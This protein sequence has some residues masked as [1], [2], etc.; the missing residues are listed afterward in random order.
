MTVKINGISHIFQ[1]KAGEIPALDDVSAT[2]SEGEFV[3]VVGPSGCGKSTLLRIVAGLITPTQG[4]IEID[5]KSVEEP[6]GD[7]GFVFQKPVLFPW[8][9][10]TANVMFPYEMRAQRDRDLRAKRAAYEKRAREL[11]E[12][13]GLTGFEKSYPRE[14]SG[15]MAQRVSICRALLL[16][17]QVLLMDEPFGALDEFSRDRLNV[18]LLRIW[19]ETRKTV[20]FV[21]H[22]IPE[23]VFL[24]DR[25]LALSPRP[26]ELLGDL[27]VDL[28]RPRT[29]E[30][31]ETVEFLQ[32]TVRV[33]KH[34]RFDEAVGQAAG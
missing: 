10:V 13:V 3:S 22:H 18:E 19:Q 25:V 5:G 8:R 32:E 28:P 23:A 29:P 4:G 1:T 17:P 12:L 2:I 34:L 27:T 14:L 33:R 20:F 30:V 9:T 15:G 6:L 24:S 31:R 7:A 11:L 21:T 26:G 16:D